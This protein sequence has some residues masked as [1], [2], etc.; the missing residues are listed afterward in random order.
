MEYWGAIL[1]FLG[2]TVLGFIWMLIQIL[3]IFEL[4]SVSRNLQP[5]LIK[6]VKMVVSGS[7]SY[8]SGKES[9]CQRRRHKRRKFYPWVRKSPLEEEMATHCSILPWKIQWTEEHGEL[10]S[11]G[12]QRVRHDWVTNT[13]FTLTP[14][15]LAVFKGLGFFVCLGRVSCFVFVCFGLLRKGLSP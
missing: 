2:P 3:K 10:Q 5:F 1:G 8:T 4:H 11:M 12:L 7:P 9:A 6:H 14:V 15:L 13:Y